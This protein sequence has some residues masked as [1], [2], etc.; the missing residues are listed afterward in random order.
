MARICPLSVISPVM[1]IVLGTC[2]SDN[3]DIIDITIVIPDLIYQ[4][5]QAHWQTNF[6]FYLLMAHLS[7]QLRLAHGYAIL[8]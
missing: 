3:N 8:I 5:M 6:F 2:L 7:G 1:A 4:S